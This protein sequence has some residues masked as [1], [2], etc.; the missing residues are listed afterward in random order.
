MATEVRIVGRDGVISVNDGHYGFGSKFVGLPEPAEIHVE[1]KH[2]EVPAV[3]K[4]LKWTAADLATATQE[5]RFPIAGNTLIRQDWKL[6]WFEDVV[7][8]WVVKMR[9]D[10]GR[11]PGITARSAVSERP[12]GPEAFRARGGSRVRSKNSRRAPPF[13]LLTLKCHVSCRGTRRA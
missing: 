12:R 13:D 4:K 1:R 7:D 11:A 8:A 3:L 10:I 6:V 2:I 9:A 5:Y